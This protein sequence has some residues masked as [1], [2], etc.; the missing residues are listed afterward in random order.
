MEKKQPPKYM[1]LKHEIL[2]WFDEGRL[3]RGDQMPSENEIA[4]QFQ[5]SRQTVRQTFG[6]LE[7]DGWLERI[8][9][10]GTFVSAPQQH[11]SVNPEVPTIGIL[12]TYISDYIFPHIVQGAEAVLRNRGYRLVLSSTDNDKERERENLQALLSQPLSGLI[13]EPTR[14]AEGN[15]NLSYYLSLDLEHIPFLMINERYAEMDCPYMKMDD[16]AGGFMATEHLIQQGHRHIAGFFKMDD[17]QGVN[18]L[19]GFIRAHR[20]YDMPL[21]P[22]S[23]IHYKTEEKQTKPFEMALSLLSREVNRPTAFVSYNDELAVRLLEAIRQADMN[24]PEDVSVVGFDDSFLATATETK[25]TT[26]VHPKNEMGKRAAEQLIDMIE[27][28]IKQPEPYIYKPELIIRE[29]TRSIE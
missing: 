15:P 26:V 23:V 19:K 4:E 24:V 10:K 8:Q 28:N 21:Q 6:E 22:D 20:E 16:E 1:Q 5:L 17:L 7:K 25:L 14:S 2:T 12:T 3:K 13:I 9:G 18:R 27:G 29:S 11:R